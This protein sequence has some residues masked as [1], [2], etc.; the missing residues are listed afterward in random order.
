[1]SHN[2]LTD[3]ISGLRQRDMWLTRALWDIKRRY[4][5][6]LLGPVW[7][8]GGLATM[9]LVVGLLYAQVFGIHREL[10]LP[11][12]AAGFL[13]WY[14]VSGVLGIAPQA[15]QMGRAAIL[16][17]NSPMSTHIYRIVMRELIVFAHNLIVYL[18]VAA[19]Y[20][21]LVSIQFWWFP[22]TMA[23]LIINVAWMALIVACLSV[24]YA[25]VPPIVAYGLLLSM[26]VTPL[27]WVPDETISSNSPVLLYNPFYYLVT[28]VRDPLLGRTPELHIWT[29]AAGMA[30]VGWAA[31][32]GVFHLTRRKIALAL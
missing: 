4:T 9:S 6:S 18:V 28:L 8:A 21:V 16:H 11:H 14:F 13:I 3:V 32:L 25:D 15:F 19:I 17:S 1:M 5:E 10:I 12:I 31:A 23:L 7:I 26:F 22:P 29:G 24:L 30:V 27:F 2:A 20:G